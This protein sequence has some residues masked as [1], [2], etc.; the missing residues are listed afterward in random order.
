MSN[1]NTT[2]V[3]ARTLSEGDVI[4]SI[5]ATVESTRW[6]DFDI[7]VKTSAGSFRYGDETPVE[8]FVR[9]GV[10]DVQV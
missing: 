6:H 8:I 5:Q 7:I 4:V 10:N 2:V 1:P 3:P 9:D